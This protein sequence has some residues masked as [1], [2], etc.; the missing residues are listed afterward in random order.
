VVYSSVVMPLSIM[1][2]CLLSCRDQHK[3]ERCSSPPSNVCILE[4]PFAHAGDD[5]ILTVRVD[6]SNRLGQKFR[7]FQLHL[8]DIG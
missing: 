3:F 8:N 5:E 1:C 4:S 2:A 6:G 7:D